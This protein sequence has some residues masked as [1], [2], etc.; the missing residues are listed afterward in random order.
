M[1]GFGGLDDTCGHAGFSPL[2]GFW[3][4]AMERMCH[5]RPFA[6]VIWPGGLPR[7]C[8]VRLFDL[9]DWF[10][11]ARCLRL[12]GVAGLLVTSGLCPFRPFRGCWM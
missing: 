10:P 6:M 1:A 7:S 5:A 12:C 11:A 2:C 4:A 3:V 8:R 9:A